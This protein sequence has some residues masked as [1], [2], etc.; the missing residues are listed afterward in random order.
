[1]I[2]SRKTLCICMQ[3]TTLKASVYDD[4][5][6]PIEFT[7]RLQYNYAGVHL[8]AINTMVAYLIILVRRK[9]LFNSIFIV[10]A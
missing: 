3:E 1:M 2:R 7:N 6:L 9:R 5:N 8:C 10:F 4:H